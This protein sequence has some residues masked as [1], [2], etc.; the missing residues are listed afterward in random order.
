VILEDLDLLSIKPDK[1][2][3]SSDHFDELLKLCTKLISEGKA[4]VDDTEPETMKEQREKRVESANR[5][6]GENVLLFE[7]FLS[8]KFCNFF[9]RR[10]EK[11]ANVA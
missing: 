1:Y 10:F 4:Y 7:I 11:F 2:T 3:H 5:Q 6:N 8:K 9:C